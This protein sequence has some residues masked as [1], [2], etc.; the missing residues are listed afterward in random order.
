MQT[1]DGE[2]VQG[3]PTTPTLQPP[4][5]AQTWHVRAAQIQ[6]RSSFATTET[7]QVAWWRRGHP[8][9]VRREFP[10]STATRAVGL[11]AVK[12]V[13]HGTDVV[14]HLSDICRYLKSLWI[15]FERQDIIERALRSLDL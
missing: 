2:I 8:R 12:T 1:A 5:E 9:E 13:V 4:G 10:E 7:G 6:T 11:D 3:Y 15:K 14:H